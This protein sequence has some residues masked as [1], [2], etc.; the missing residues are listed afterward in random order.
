ML[1]TWQLGQDRLE[2]MEAQKAELETAIADLKAELEAVAAMIAA[3][4]ANGG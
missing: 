4:K 2:A 1:R 3:R